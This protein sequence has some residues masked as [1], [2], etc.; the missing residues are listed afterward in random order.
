M[1]LSLFAK[2]WGHQQLGLRIV[3]VW[4]IL[5]PSH[6]LLYAKVEGDD[7]SCSSLLLGPPLAVNSLHAQ[8]NSASPFVWYTLLPNLIFSLSDG[9]FGGAELG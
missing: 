8:A 4:G 2:I 5:K 7:F 3:I 1:S 6:K 9:L